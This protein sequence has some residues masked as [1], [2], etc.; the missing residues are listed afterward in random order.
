VVHFRHIAPLLFPLLHLHADAP[1][2]A[3]LDAVLLD[4]SQYCRSER[5]RQ[6]L[7]GG[8]FGQLVQR[9]HTEVERKK[10]VACFVIVAAFVV[11]VLTVVTVGTEYRVEAQASALPQ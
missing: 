6:L 7:G 11:A 3:V 10:L 4:A 1:V 2:R 8:I 5:P 9:S